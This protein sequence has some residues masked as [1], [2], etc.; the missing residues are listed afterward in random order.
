MCDIQE[1]PHLPW[2]WQGVS[3]NPN[4]TID[5]IENNWDKNW[6]F[7]RLSNAECLNCCFLDRHLDKNWNWKNISRSVYI[8][9]D[10]LEKY[11]H[12]PWDFD[13]MSVNKN[14][15]VD[16]VCKYQRENW[17]WKKMSR[18]EF[19]HFLDLSPDSDYYMKRKVQSNNMCEIIRNELLLKAFHP[20]RFV[21][22]CL[23]YDDYFFMQK[24]ENG[25]Q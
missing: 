24:F 12:F 25:T 22:W 19:H 9:V 6:C 5:F 8:S 1:N 3:L 21:D 20:K 13:E 11:S 7:D 10:I 18:N 15:N 23:A 14:L 4:L 16:I 17:N 2:D